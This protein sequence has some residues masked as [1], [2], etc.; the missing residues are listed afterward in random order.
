MI[1]ALEGD[2]IDNP[3]DKTDS[4]IPR[5][6]KSESIGGFENHEKRMRLGRV[7]KKSENK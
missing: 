4:S 2:S 3:V 6:S 5:K 1:K 7:H